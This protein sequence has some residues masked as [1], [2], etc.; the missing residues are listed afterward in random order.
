MEKVSFDRILSSDFILLNLLEFR[1]FE[2][3]FAFFHLSLLPEFAVQ[4]RKTERS[5]TRSF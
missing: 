5:G 2:F 3:G 1:W 4:L